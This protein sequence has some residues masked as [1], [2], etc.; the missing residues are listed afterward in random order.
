ME[1]KSNLDDF[2]KQTMIFISMLKN[3]PRDSEDNMVAGIGSIKG[4]GTFYV[5]LN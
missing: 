5:F 4:F 2:V 1:E 3:I